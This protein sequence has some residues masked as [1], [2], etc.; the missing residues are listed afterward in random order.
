MPIDFHNSDRRYEPVQ[1]DWRT[2]P[3]CYMRPALSEAV[4]A[5]NDDAE[6]RAAQRRA[7]LQMLPLCCLQQSRGDTAQPYFIAHT[8][9]YGEGTVQ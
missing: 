2:P 9:L 7:A 5:S 1:A 3:R 8:L 4:E 6:G